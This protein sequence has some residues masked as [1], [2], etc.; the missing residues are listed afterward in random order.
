MIQ[1][2][3]QEDKMEIKS[4]Q[5]PSPSFTMFPTK[6]TH[7]TSD[8]ITHILSPALF[9]IEFP[10]SAL[11]LIYIDCD[12]PPPRSPLW[13]PADGP[14]IG[15]AG[16]LQLHRRR[17]CHGTESLQAAGHGEHHVR[18]TD[19]SSSVWFQ[20]CQAV[21]TGEAN[22]LTYRVFNNAPKM[23]TQTAGTSRR[24][25]EQIQVSLLW[26]CQSALMLASYV[27]AYSF[28]LCCKVWN[29]CID[30]QS[31]PKV[32]GMRRARKNFTYGWLERSK[33]S[34]RMQAFPS[35]DIATC[36]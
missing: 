33:Q 7:L 5:Q 20:P 10:I 1:E 31:L 21:Y 28:S 6:A 36:S 24:L 27:S 12:L 34:Y 16:D 11:L 4:S 19:Q 17:R 18:L 30:T 25:W 9:S 2:W 35:C 29:V 22:I 15:H 13:H 8:P 14:D 3:L 26:L 23:L 32:P